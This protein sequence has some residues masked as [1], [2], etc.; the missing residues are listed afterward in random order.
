MTLRSGDTGK[1]GVVRRWGL[2]DNEDGL[3]FE[4]SG[5]DFS[6]NVRN[7]SVGGVDQK[8]ERFSFNGDTLDT[9]GLSDYI[10]DFSKINLYW[11]DYQWL[12]AGR[13]RF[14]VIGPDG[15]KIVLHNVYNAN[16]YLV[17]Y[18]K[19]ST[20]P[21]RW[22]IR[23][24]TGTASTSEL[25][26]LCATV[27]RQGQDKGFEANGKPFAH[28]SNGFVTCNTGS[29]TPLMTFR[30]KDNIGGLENKTIIFPQV[31]EFY[32]DTHPIEVDLFIGNTLAGETFSDSEPFSNVDIDVDATGSVGG[33]RRVN[34]LQP[35]GV[36]VREID[37]SMN[38]VSGIN[39]DGTKDNYTVAAKS[40]GA[41][42]T[43]VRFLTKWLEIN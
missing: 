24:I 9:E 5:S 29:Y 18:M 10:I 11:I 13:A 4:L 43:Q 34:Y 26:I 39:E 33:F 23:N 2:F 6:V 32:S 35:Q 12:G 19:R 42:D 25:H 37:P 31:F 22:E 41:G 17:P 14:G 28:S 1:E 16:K 7:S 40:L 36:S 27:Q 21:V 3:F 15:G 20:F 38:N 30:L 8:V